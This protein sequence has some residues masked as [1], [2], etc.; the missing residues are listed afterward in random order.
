[1]RGIIAGLLASAAAAATAA[2]TSAPMDVTA[3][4]QQRA[5]A[6][7]E[8]ELITQAQAAEA[9]KDWPKA[10]SLLQRLVDLEPHDWQHHQALADA[11]LN[12]GDYA[13]ALQAY[14]AA[15]AITGKA[16][17]TPALNEAMSVIYSDEGTAYLKLKRN[18]EAVQA[19]T[20]AAQLSAHP[21]TPWFNL[22]AL[23]YNLGDVDAGLKACE[24]AIAAD[25]TKA[26]AYFIKGSLLMGNASLDAAG[27]VVAPS[28]T[29]EA[30]QKYLAL[31][32]DG[33]H[34][35]DVKQMLAYLNGQP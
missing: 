6:I 30:L 17:V 29:A 19:F 28:G 1:M 9:A 32:P 26:D 15:L 27:K 10:E 22:C 20:Q 7:K 11:R 16:K 2:P 12:G 4:K 14:A 18:A 35:A 24:Q 21:A 3:L 34:A 25:P 33:P 8:N 13:G 23:H 31:A 5:Q